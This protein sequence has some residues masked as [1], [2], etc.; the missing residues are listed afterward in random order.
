MH[1]E[2]YD[3]TGF[4]AAADSLSAAETGAE[5]G[6]LYDWLLNEYLRLR[7][8]SELVWIEYYAS[9]G[10]NERISDACQQ[11]DDALTDAGDVFLSAIA[12]A[13][14]GPAAEEFA[15]KLGEQQAEELSEHEDMTEREAQLWARE[16][17]LKLEYNEWV[18]REDLSAFR[19]N[20]TLGGIFL[21]LVSVRNELASIRGYDSYADYAYESVYGRD[22]TP[23]DAAALCEAIK[24]FAR[25]YY[26]C[27]DADATYITYYQPDFGLFSAGELMDLLRK[28]APEISAEAAEALEYME[29]H[30]LYLV[31]STN[32]VSSVGFTTLLPRYNAPF[33]FDGLYGYIYDLQSIFHEFGHYYDA[34]INPEPEDG[35]GS[36]GSYDVF[37]IH[38]TSMEA[39][40]Y[41]WYDEI[42]SD[43]ALDARIAGLDSLICNIISGCMYDEF[44]QYVY[45]HP[46]MSV[47]EVNQ[48]YSDI[49]ASYGKTVGGGT[50]RYYW[51]YVSHNFESPF[52]YISYAAST[53]ASLQLWALAEQDRPAALALYD[54]I[55]HIGAY[56]MGYCELLRSV[57]MQVFT[58]D[59]AG[60]FSEAVDR[61]K[62]LCLEY[63]YAAAA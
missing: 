61:L 34:Y 28:Y 21:E 43:Q 18:D 16:T 47:A 26:R 32:I 25:E 4:Y 51:M 23:A 37:E 27:C 62:E 56:D 19:L 6:E 13:L 10:A 48:A 49:A 50:G 3:M 24:P 60:C 14:H 46:G 39:L 17:E 20:K 45:S 7:T 53:L 36:G 41:G 31:E 29:S 9:G 11:I 2:L 57:G 54:D 33:L 40:L 35:M 44:L 55:V 63:E 59:P 38:S 52:Y 15:A 8:Y 12:R 1:W 5:A 42:F 58:D 30:N 22:Y